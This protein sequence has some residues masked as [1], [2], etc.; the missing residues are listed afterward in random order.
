MYRGLQRRRWP[1]P[2]MLASE[3]RLNERA[4]TGNDTLLADLEKER[5]LLRESVRR[6]RVLSEVSRILLDYTGDDDIEPL[7]RI[8]PIV[9][10][11]LGDWCA[12]TLIQPDGTLKNVAHYHPDPRQ[13][14][15]ALLV[16]QVM[17]PR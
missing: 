4:A 13:R 7:R 9:V 8:V 10:E 16:E 15:L 11:A 17:P 2:P 12:F 5:A 6:Q 14:E 1:S 3:I